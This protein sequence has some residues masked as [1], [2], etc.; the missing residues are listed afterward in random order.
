MTEIKSEFRTK[1]EEFKKEYEAERKG[2]N[3]FR[4]LHKE[5]DEKYLHSR[6]ISY[7]LSPASTHG[8]ENKFLKLFIDRVSEAYPDLKFNIN[9]CYVRPN[10]REKGEIDDIDIRISNEKQVIIIENKI[11]AR[12]SNHPDKVEP[13]ERI[14]LIRCYNKVK[15][16]DNKVFVVYLT[17]DGHDP[18]EIE[19][20]KQFFPVLKIEYRTE[21]LEWIESCIN[22][23]EDNY[24]K[25]TL[26]QYEKVINILTNDVKRAKELQSKIGENIEEAWHEEDTRCFIFEMEDFKHVQWHTI[27]KFWEELAIKLVEEPINAKITNRIT[28]EEISGIVHKNWKGSYGITFELKNGQEWYIVNDNINGLSFGKIFE[29]RITLEQIDNILNSK[30]NE[31]YGICFILDDGKEWYITNDK[32]KSTYREKLEEMSKNKHRIKIWFEISKNIKFTDF[33]NEDTFMLIN[34]KKRGK[35]IDEII[36]MLKE[37]PL[38]KEPISIIL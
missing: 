25:E 8:M 31:A 15:T 17:L 26:K 16:K 37:N 4:A 19:S 9:E 22:I 13:K 21:I 14:Q 36:N 32:I 6:F 10:E 38:L 5:H 24:L 23:L 20:I 35:R 2:F 7:L 3:I 29:G 33:S 1:L 27:D 18:E 30:N 12:D 11:Y 34:A 28:I